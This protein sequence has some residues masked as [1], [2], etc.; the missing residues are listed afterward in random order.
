MCASVDM[1][2]PARSCVQPAAVRAAWTPARARTHEWRVDGQMFRLMFP[3]PLMVETGNAVVRHSSA[4]QARECVLF[5]GTPSVCIYTGYVYIQAMYV[6]M[7]ICI[8]VCIHICIYVYMYIFIYV[9]PAIQAMYIYRLCI[10]T[11][12]VYLQS[13]SH[14]GEWK[15]SGKTRV[16]QR[17][18]IL[19]VC[20]LSAL[21]FSGRL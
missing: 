11:G 16:Q 7:C 19:G 2:A 20:F 13:M 3:K 5:I 10:H 1:R 8:Y 15:C 18:V 12:C 4:I 14:G 17:R 21:F 9:Y 6:Y